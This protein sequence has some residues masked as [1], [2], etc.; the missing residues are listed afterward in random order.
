M[1]GHPLRSIGRAARFGLLTFA[2]IRYAH[3][4][5]SSLLTLCGGFLMAVL[6]FDLMFDVQVLRM[7]RVEPSEEILASIAAY[8]A[9]VTGSPMGRLVGVVMLIALSGTLYQLISGAIPRG[10]AALALATT[11][12]PVLL[13]ALR[14]LPNAVRLGTR[15]DPIDGQ[16]CLAHSIYR[17]H[18]ACLVSIL[19]FSALELL[20]G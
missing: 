10:I 2:T 12:A 18:L 1:L 19:T 20:G 4:T 6:W 16:A 13:A 7:S 17:E 15:A 11:A 5:M 3:D 14:V 8:Y 9:R